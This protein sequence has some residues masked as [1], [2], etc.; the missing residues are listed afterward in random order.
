MF[1]QQAEA[2]AE[3]AAEG[4]VVEVVEE[5][6]VAEAKAEG[7]PAVEEVV[8]N[9]P[10]QHQNLL[11]PRKYQEH[12]TTTP[13]TMGHRMTPPRMIVRTRTTAR[14]ILAR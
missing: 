9:P 3:A 12:Q 6:V 2:A 8:A 13:Q 10:R 14:S 4:E 7:I 5:A 1:S 11:R